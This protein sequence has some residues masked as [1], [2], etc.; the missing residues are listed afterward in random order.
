MF[1]WIEYSSSGTSNKLRWLAVQAELEAAE[2]ELEP[3]V[4]VS[5][6]GAGRVAVAQNEFQM[7]QAT[8]HH[9]LQPST[10][11]PASTNLSVYVHTTCAS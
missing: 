11:N 2:D 7:R 9:Y 4:A 5:F 1:S 6:E 3:T 10:C 8:I